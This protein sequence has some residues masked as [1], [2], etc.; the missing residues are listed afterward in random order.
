M[1]VDID[2]ADERWEEYRDLA[3]RAAIAALEHLEFESDS[4]ELA[5]KLSDDEEVQRLNSLYRG[6]NEPTNVL[7]FEADP[8]HANLPES[9]SQPIGDVILAFETVEKE[10]GVQEKNLENH[11]CHL[12]VHGVLHLC[13]YS[14]DDDATA[15]AMEK[16]EITILDELGIA[17]PYLLKEPN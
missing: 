6:K 17:N 15:Q 16:F 12:I 8:P 10:A 1:I 9:Q 2:I 3:V 7:S 14:H 4:A 11:L 13:G 5:L